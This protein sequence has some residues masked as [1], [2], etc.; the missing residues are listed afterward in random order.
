MSQLED[1]GVLDDTEHG[2]LVFGQ[3][4]ALARRRLTATA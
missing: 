4:Q 2:N 3:W 1:H